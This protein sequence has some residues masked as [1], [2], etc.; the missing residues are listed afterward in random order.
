MGNRK[1]SQFLRHLRILWTSHLSTNVR[2]ILAR[3]PEVDLEAAALSADSIMETISMPT[4]ASVAPG[5]D[6]MELERTVHN[7][8]KQ[9][10]DLI[11]EQKRT[12]TSIR[13]N[14]IRDHRSRSNSRRSNSSTRNRRQSPVQQDSNSTVCWYHQR[15]GKLAQRCSWPC[16]FIIENN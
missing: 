12:N 4:V 8:S 11:A 13:Q 5:T 7:L 9:V 1:P 16:T 2:T 6:Y 3:L 10:A 15:F 14:N